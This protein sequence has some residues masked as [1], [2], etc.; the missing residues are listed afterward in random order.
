MKKRK[1][2]VGQR[3]IVIYDNIKAV[4]VGYYEDAGY[5]RYDV[6]HLFGSHK[7][8]VFSYPEWSIRKFKKKN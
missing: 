8:D 1:Y 7:K 4:V 2:N 3:V 6:K 5:W